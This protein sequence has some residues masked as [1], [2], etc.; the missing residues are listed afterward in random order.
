VK[1]TPARFRLE[2][3]GTAC[4]DK[5]VGGCRRG[6]LSHRYLAQTDEP[7]T[8][9]NYLNNRYHDPALGV[10]ISVD[11]LVSSTREPYIYGSGGPVTFSDPSGLEPGCGATAT[12]SSSCGAAHHEVSRVFG[13]KSD[14]NDKQKASMDDGFVE[15]RMW[16]QFR[17][18]MNQW[19]ECQDLLWHGSDRWDLNDAEQAAAYEATR[20]VVAYII[21]LRSAGVLILG[22]SEGSGDRNSVH[23]TSDNDLAVNVRSVGYHLG[24]AAMSLETSSDD[25][26]FSIGGTGCFGFCVRLG[27]VDFTHI[28]AGWGPYGVG[29]S[30]DMSISTQSACKQAGSGYAA[31]FVAGVGGGISVAS[32]VSGVPDPANVTFTGSVGAKVGIAPG[33]GIFATWVSGC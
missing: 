30:A 2:P 9:L 21:R 18:C 33:G 4:V 20:V 29:V 10:F 31:S 12:S 16:V 8:N 3:G 5:V 7:A 22:G 32:S 25:L 24:V 15:E 1:H 23:L 19:S 17:T 26:A 6:L 27:V 11:P 28:Y 14:L 13:N